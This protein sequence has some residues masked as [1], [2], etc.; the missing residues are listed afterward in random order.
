MADIILRDKDDAIDI[1]NDILNNKNK[2]VIFDTET[3]GLGENDVIVQIGLLDLDDNAL[4]DTLIK[5]TKRKKM[6]KQ[7][8]K[9]T[10]YP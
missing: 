3:T 8:K 2:Y 10:A 1:A 7:L 9:F 4:M 6:S 5:P